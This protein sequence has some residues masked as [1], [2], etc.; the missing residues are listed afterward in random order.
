MYMNI[1]IGKH[2]ISRKEFKKKHWSNYQFLQALKV[3]KTCEIITK[4]THCFTK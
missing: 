2:R 3:F 1:C 4:S